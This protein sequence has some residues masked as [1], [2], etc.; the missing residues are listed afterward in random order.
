MAG[1]AGFALTVASGLQYTRVSAEILFDMRRELY[2][3]LQRLSPR[4]YA[5]TRLGDIV[6]RI[7][8]DIGEIQRVAAEAA[9]AWVGNVLFLAGGIAILVWLDWRLF[10][11]GMATLPLSAWALVRYRRRIEGATMELRQRSADLGSFLIETLAGMRTVVTSGGRF[12]GG[13][14]VEGE[15]IVAVGPDAGLPLA[16]RVIDARGHYVLPGLIDQIVGTALLMLMILA[17]TDE[18]NSPPGSNLAPLM[19]GLVVVAIGMAFGGMHGYAINPAR[20]FGPRLF[21]VL[22]GFKNNGLTD[23]SGVWWVPIVGPIAGALLGAV[24]WDQ[25][26]RKYLPKRPG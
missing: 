13:V 11:A 18:R 16:R 22:A 15:R 23:G 7:N 17:I 19:I 5:G 26:V 9:L 8:N 3:H 12:P 20:D 24:V 2:E 25:G 6:S 4:F 10:L 21:T 14:A 1:A